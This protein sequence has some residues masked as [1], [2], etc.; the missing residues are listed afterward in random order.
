MKNN[1]SS[2]KSDK[3]EIGSDKISLQDIK[4]DL[5]KSFLTFLININNIINFINNVEIDQ[6]N[7]DLIKINYHIKKFN[8]FK[9]DSNIANEEIKSDTFNSNCDDMNNFRDSKSIDHCDLFIH[10][11]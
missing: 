3:K 1:E 10:Q 2:I 5:Y 7:E 6:K 4:K 11:F 8:K 9:L